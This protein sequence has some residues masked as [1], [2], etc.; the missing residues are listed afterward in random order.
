MSFLT[1][2]VL[3]GTDWRAVERA[4]ARLISHCGWSSVRIIGGTGDGGGDVVGVRNENGRRVTYVIQVKSI[5]GDSY[6]GQSAIQEVLNAMHVYDAD[7]GVVA[8]NGDFT[9]TAYLRRKQLNANGFDVRLWNG[10]FLTKLL[11]HFPVNHHARRDLRPYQVDIV[12]RC[13]DKFEQG[14]TRVQFIVAT[15]LGKTVIAAEIASRLFERGLRRILVLCHMQDLALQL[16]QNFWFQLDKTVPT[17]VFFDGEMPK[18]I[19]GVN[20][21][22]YQTFSNYLNGIDPEDYDIVIVDEAHHSLAYGFR[23]CLYHLHPRLLIGMTATPWRGDGANI[24]SIFSWPVARVSLVDGMKAG[25]LA[26]ADYRI[27]CDTLNWDDISKTSKGKVSIRDL[28]KQLFVP[29]RDEAITDELIKQCK[30]V[31]NPRV[32]VFCAS[33]EH[34]E[35]FAELVSTSSSMICKRISGLKKIDRNRTLMEFASGKIQAVTA[36]DVLNEGIDV[37]DVNILVFLRSTHSRRIFVQ[38]LG[39]GLRLAENKEKLLVLDFVT[40]VRR[41][42]ELYEMDQEARKPSGSKYQTLYFKEGIVTFVNKG[43]LPFVQQWIKDVTDL[44][45]AKESAQLDFPEPYDSLTTKN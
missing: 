44:G 4:V 41:L 31:T 39:R 11:E 36:V 30:T 5:M 22:L 23:K 33:I 45:D 25:Y 13:I 38:Q 18:P 32:I 16:E 17:R 7:V 27:Y 35:R 19:E 14:H 12:D 24:D 20:V 15:G 29:Q 2:G 6:V 42:A 9:Q 34:C 3:K 28:N 40:D 43:I 8:T 26:Q 37:P 21:G 1:E 10:L